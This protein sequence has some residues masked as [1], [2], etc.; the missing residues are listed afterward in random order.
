[1][2]QKSETQKYMASSPDQIDAIRSAVAD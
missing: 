2:Q 1:L